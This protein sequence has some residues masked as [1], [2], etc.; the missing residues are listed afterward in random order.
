MNCATG[1]VTPGAHRTAALLLAMLGQAAAQNQTGQGQQPPPT[2]GYQQGQQGQG[3]QQPAV[4]P[5]NLDPLRVND[6]PFRPPDTGLSPF[7]GFPTFPPNLGGYGVYP[8]PKILTEPPSF[9]GGALP[10]LPPGPPDWPSWLQFR[11]TKPMPYAPN[12][13][14]LVRITDRVWFKTAAEE[15]FVPCYFFDKVRPVG[16]GTAVQVRQSGEFELLLQDGSA[17]A[18]SG[19]TQ[20][21]IAALDDQL[22]RLDLAVC[23]QARV[24][25]RE[26]AHELRLPDGSAVLV[27]AAPGGRGGAELHLQRLDEPG[28]YGGRATL[29]H[30]GGAPVTWRTP[31][32]DHVL[33]SGFRVTL[34]LQ[35][36]PSARPVAFKGVNVDVTARGHTLVCRGRDGGGEVSWSGARVLV[37]AGAQLD[38][39]PLLGDPFAGAIGDKR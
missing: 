34:F 4:D 10:S 23:T 25:C 28:L 9:A 11:A 8:V 18:A 36:A 13:A 30:A 22:V 29:F 2:P 16:V 39:D 15:A 1:I 5:W 12:V 7:Q 27:P 19:P 35:P 32:G 31:L 26:R 21:L 17:F 37:P 3:A 38:L 33:A 6:R 20:L 14:V 24:R